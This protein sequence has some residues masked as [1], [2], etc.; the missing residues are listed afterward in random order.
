[1]QRPLVVA[2]RTAAVLLIAGGIAMTTAGAGGLPGISALSQIR[3]GAEASAGQ[4]NSGV[5]PAGAGDRAE[6]QAV[7]QASQDQGMPAAQRQAAPGRMAVGRGA[8][9]RPEQRTRAQ[10]N[11]AQGK[12]TAT[13][14][15]APRRAAQT[16]RDGVRQKITPG[17]FSMSLGDP[18]QRQ[19]LALVNQNRRRGGCGGV[20]LDHRLIVSA[21]KHAADMARHGYFA[22]ESLAGVGSS[23]RM[24]AA[25][26]HWSRYGENIARGPGSAQEAV[27]GWM[28]SPAHREN[29]LDCRLREMGIGVAV[30][31]DGTPYWVQ[32]FATPR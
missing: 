19:V 11:S 4:R 13:A 21:Y 17:D 29:I 25:G 22:H 16:S 27:D 7:F 3:R 32:D 31:G 24:W 8:L 5:A 20:A 15:T 6:I 2:R 10:R 23:D 1:M 18:T 30:A 12:A 14:G 28:N 9:A 26:F